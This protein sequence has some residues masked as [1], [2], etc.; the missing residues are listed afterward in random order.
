MRTEKALHREKNNNT[1]SFY[2]TCYLLNSDCT[3]GHGKRTKINIFNLHPRTT[4]KPH[5]ESCEC[6]MWLHVFVCAVVQTTGDSGG[7][8]NP[9]PPGSPVV[10]LSRWCRPGSAVHTPTHTKSTQSEGN[11]RW[12]Y[13][14]KRKNKNYKCAAAVL[15]SRTTTVKKLPL[16]EPS[17]PAPAQRAQA[18]Y[19]QGRRKP[20]LRVKQRDA[21]LVFL[22]GPW[23]T[24]EQGTSAACQPALFSLTPSFC[25]GGQLWSCVQ[26]P[27]CRVL[28]DGVITERLKMG[29]RVASWRGREKVTGNMLLLQI[30]ILDC[31]C[32]SL[33]Y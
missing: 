29:R 24:S 30:N 32:C 22:T 27:A 7:H 5:W 14:K 1:N 25:L 4:P 12:S 20:N 31:L 23:V 9:P 28:I 26:H 10:L 2:L 6:T 17:E 3:T 16:V 18:D 33:M 21:G 8:P 19:D 13:T 15:V 11:C